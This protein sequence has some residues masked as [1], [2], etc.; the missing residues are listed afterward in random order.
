MVYNKSIGFG[1]GFMF[2]TPQ[3]PGTLLT[4]VRIG[5]M[6]N[7]SLDFQFDEKPL[8]GQNQFPEAVAR[9]KA[10]VACKCEFAQID[11]LAIGTVFLGGVPAAGQGIIIDGE[12][13]T[14]AGTSTTITHTSGFAN[15]G[16]MYAT[17]FQPLTQV[18]AG[19]ET[20]GSYSVAAGGV[21]TFGTGDSTASLLFSYSYNDTAGKKTAITNQPMGTFIPFQT[22]LF[23]QNPEV[24]G[25]QWGARLY[26]CSSAKLSLATKQD[27]WTIP[28]MEFSIFANPAGAVMDFNTPN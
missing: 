20:T 13:R 23:E 27:D 6:Q 24:A 3:S 22:D 26:K 28:N 17:T 7:V 10:K 19:S 21:Y 9:G 11:S 8:Y 12:A 14:L 16:V 5:I 4:P 15:L 18:N 25:G 2:M 1:S